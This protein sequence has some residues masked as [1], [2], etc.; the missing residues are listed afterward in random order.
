MTALLDPPAVKSEGALDTRNWREFFH[1]WPAGVSQRGVLITLLNESIPFISFVSSQ[2][3]LLIERPSPD[4]IGARRV[5]VPFSQIAG[6]KFT[7]VLDAKLFR[8]V[9]F[10]QTAVAERRK[11][12]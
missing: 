8:T 6:V 4:A 10:K 11:V 3:M 12:E 2:D 7:D 1:N 5:L 9:G